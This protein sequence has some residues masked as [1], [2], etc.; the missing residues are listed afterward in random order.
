MSRP[1]KIIIITAA[2]LL[3]GLLFSAFILPHIVRA[4]LEKQI[5]AA[6]ERNCSVEKV[7]I[8]P[9]NWSVEVVGVKLAE[10]KSDAVFVSFSSLKLQVS[11]SSVWHLAPV[12]SG[13][14]IV[15]PY[16]HLQRNA[17][18]SYN[19]TDIIEK[20][21]KKSSSEP[22]RFSLNNIVIENG[23]VVFDDNARAETK[24]HTIEKLALQ[25][26]FVSNISYFAD[27]YVDPKLTATVNGA[28]LSFAG[29]LKPF[30]KGLEASLDI[31]LKGV[32]IPYYAAY[33][34]EKLPVKIL[35]GDLSAGLRI[36]HQ[37]IQKGKPDI[38]ISGTLSLHD[39]AV[40]EL[41]G[42]NLFSLKALTVA[43]AKAALLTQRYEFAKIALENPQLAVRGEKDGS[44]NLLRLKG[45]PGAGEGLKKSEPEKNLPGP[46]IAVTS[47][48]I[49]DGTITIKDEH[50]PGGCSVELKGIA[51]SLTGFASK[52]E[53][54]A[55]YTL[56]LVTG[57]KE[58]ASAAGS[59]S[60]EPFAISSRIELADI[61]LEGASPYLAAVLNDPV[62]GRGGFS[63]DLAYSAENG[64]TV[65]QALL[66]LTDVRI[67]FGQN[68]G[69]LIPSALAE[70]VSLKLKAKTLAVGKVSLSGGKIAV[71]RDSAGTFSPTLLVKARGT[72]PTSVAAAAKPDRPFSWKIGRF[73]LNGLRASFQDNMKEAQPKFELAGIRAEISSIHGPDFSE[74]PVSIAADSG[75]QGSVSIGGRVTLAPFRFRGDIACK[76][77]PFADFDPYLPAGVNISL[78]DG[79]LDTKLSADFFMKDNRLYGSFQGQG[80]I[81]DFYSVDAVEEND[82]LKWESLLLERLNGS[83]EPFT[84]SVSGVSLNNYYARVIVKKSGRTNLQDIY[85]TPVKAAAP[86]APP[87]PQKPASSRDIRIDTVTL[88]DGTLDFSDH[89]LNRDFATTMLNLGGRISGLSSVEGS[90]ADIDLRGNLENHSPLK[91]SGRINPLAKD[92]FLDMQILFSDIELSPLTPY[93]GTYL[94]YVIEK[95]KL[96]L[97]L[98]YK[99]DKKVL[100]AENKVFIDQFTFGDKVESPK[101]TSLP[102]R[103][104]VALLKDKNG[105]IHLDLPLSGRTDSPKFS[106]WGL[107]GQ[108]LKNLLVKAATSPFALLQASFGSGADFSSVS[109]SSGSGRLTSA[110]EDKL[111]TLARVLAER[112]GIRLEVTGFADRERDPEGYRLE[113]LLR[114]MK[115][116]KSLFTAKEKRESGGLKPDQV[117]IPPVEQSKWLKVVYEKE[118]FPKPRTVIGTLKTLPDEEMKK[119]ILA[120]TTVT[121]EQLRSLAR[122]RALAVMSFLG[123]VG[124]LPQERLFEKSTDP[125]VPSEKGS[126]F[127]GRVEFGVVAR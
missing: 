24:R 38:I 117:D 119:L 36:H 90:T 1:R 112:P 23:R 58:K 37:L 99:V 16:V 5:A 10:K 82:L 123:T 8:N 95:G 40:A 61:V 50:P 96:S 125:F 45:Q 35:K 83:L 44:W 20:H 6:T 60:M 93:S 56:S 62:R 49:S 120:N 29:R 66:R 41:S 68:D 22:T 102:V 77:F 63:G 27:T 121:E 84:L 104:A 103:F 48:L 18:N 80:G 127:A 26:P 88:S 72:Q 107:V 71:S 100:T 75:A 92:L 79:Y 65:D 52:G 98:S 89:H 126:G 69:V 34:P 122:E 28:P 19:F 108:V 81:R 11:P 33:F 64:L 25:V 30:E 51:F 74:M 42:A 110:E 15:S 70:G 124:K 55:A 2:A 97:G 7:S 73:S 76:N 57:R 47:L 13:L 32:D 43:V 115:S 12:V 21:P 78:V 101:A 3:S 85:T 39:L 91:I 17:P 105:E 53:V 113:L 59:L 118:K 14:R 9:L 106:V 87:E 86:S 46:D 109:F 116:E 114:K 67:P 111:R 54:P 94:G 4:Q 31:N